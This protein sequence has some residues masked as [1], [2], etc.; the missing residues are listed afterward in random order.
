MFNYLKLT[1]TFWVMGLT[2][3]SSVPLSHEDS[4]GYTDTGKASFYADKYHG[5]TTASGEIFSQQKLTAAHKQLAF[6]S[7]VKV[8]N[9]RNQKSVIVRI[10]DR[11]PFVSGRVIDLSR[12]AFSKIAQLNLGVIDVKIEVID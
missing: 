7:K 8:T 2:A 5:R 6:G 11:G 3:C 12:S 1:M 4:L 9:I 10:N